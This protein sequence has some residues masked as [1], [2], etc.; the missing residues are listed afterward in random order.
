MENTSSHNSDGALRIPRIVWILGAGLVVALIA[1]FVFDVPLG[2]VL[3]Y[4]LIALAMGGHL[5]MHGSHGGHAGHDEPAQSGTPQPGQTT[6]PLDAN[7]VAT[8]T[9]NSG[10]RDASHS[11]GCH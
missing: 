7:R 3:S 5:F 1:L 8:G 9:R 2:T 10:D 4:G 6:D 11:R